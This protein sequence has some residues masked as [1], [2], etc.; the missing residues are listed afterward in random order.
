M[1]LI[2]E[3]EAAIERA[4]AM[5]SPSPQVQLALYGL[6]K[7]ARTGDVSGDRPGMLEM[8]KRAKY[9][10]WAGHRGVPT[11]QAMQAYIAKVSELSG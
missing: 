7:Q 6:F 10:A 9:D 2:E 1:E 4:N 3:F 8:R 5:P 11:D